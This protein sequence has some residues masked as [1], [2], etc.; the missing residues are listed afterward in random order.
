M[1]VNQSNKLP[2]T[3]QF[4]FIVIVCHNNVAIHFILLYSQRHHYMGNTGN[5]ERNRNLSYI[6]R[7]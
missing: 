3:N 6:K 2:I 7:V 4:S 5:T 1:N